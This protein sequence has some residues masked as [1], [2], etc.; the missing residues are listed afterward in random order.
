MGYDALT[1][2]QQELSLGISQLE[3]LAKKATFPFLSANLVDSS[4]DNQTMFEPYVV[5]D[6]QGVRI[7]IMGLTEPAAVVEPLASADILP[8]VETAHRYVEELREK[9]DILIVLSHLGLEEDKA[10]AKAVPG[11]DAIIGGNTGYLMQ[12]PERVGNTLIVQQGSRGQWLGHLKASF[13]AQGVPIEFEADYIP[14]GA[15]WQDD[16]G[17]GAI[18]Q[19]YSELYPSPTPSPRATRVSTRAE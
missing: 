8:A 9:V 15:D 11:I 5:L 16:P 19:K 10:L 2:G 1:I 3:E 13:D 18:V 14:L 6:R 17:V 12:E 7:G 4:R